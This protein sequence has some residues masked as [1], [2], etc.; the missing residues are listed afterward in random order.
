MHKYKELLLKYKK[1]V[2]V[3]LVGTLIPVLIGAP[4]V[5]TRNLFFYYTILF[6]LVLIFAIR[7]D[8]VLKILPKLLLFSS[9]SA[10]FLYI[11][12]FLRV[13]I[14]N[15]IKYGELYRISHFDID[16]LGPAVMLIGY[17]FFF[18]LIGAVIYG[19][20]KLYEKQIERYFI[21]FAPLS[22]SVVSLLKVRL[23]YGGTIVSRLYGWPESILSY[24]IK[25][26]VDNSAISTW[27]FSPIYL[28]NV[29]L[30]YV[31][32]FV[33]FGLSLIAFRVIREKF[34]FKLKSFYFLF[35]FTLTIAFILSCYNGFEEQ[36]IRA[37][38]KKSRYCNV[39]ADCQ[40]IN[41]SKMGCALSVNKEK[42][43]KINTLIKNYPFHSEMRC[44]GLRYEAACLNN[45]CTARYISPIPERR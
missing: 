41:F 20:Y 9:L 22:L 23:N 44:G 42:V 39:T 14:K 5:E 21:Y 10:L 27:S 26:V 43:E 16:L 19:F 17:V 31:F 3:I 33:V 18:G 2:L 29:L 24:Q 1:I 11:F 32:Y 34:K 12:I 13:Q 6:S 30:N 4:F 37:E 7:E 38:I 8:S 45:Y 40:K 25:D 35:Y 15:L 28:S 36:Y